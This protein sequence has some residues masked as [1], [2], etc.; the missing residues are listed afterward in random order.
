MGSRGIV[1]DVTAVA[2]KRGEHEDAEMSSRESQCQVKVVGD[3][4]G[5]VASDYQRMRKEPD[6][7][8]LLRFNAGGDDGS[9]VGTARGHVGRSNLSQF[10]PHSFNAIF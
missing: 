10:F 2:R 8:P 9:T 7:S 5:K 6:P 3:I 1:G 4:V